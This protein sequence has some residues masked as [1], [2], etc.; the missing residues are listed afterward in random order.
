MVETQTENLFDRR[1]DRREVPAL[2]VH[3]MVLGQDG[4]NLFAAGV[5]DMDFMAPPV[6]LEALQQRLAHGIFGYE[7]VP[8]GLMPA[9]TAWLQSR[10]S[11]QVDPA[12][13]LRAPNVLNSLAIAASL[14]TEP[15]D[16]VIVQS[17]VFFD[18]YDILRENNRELVLNPLILNDG[19]YEMDFDGLERLAAEPRTRMIYLCNPHNPVGRVW[20]KAELQQL[21]EICA[22]YN[23]LVVSDEIHGDVTFSGHRY[24]PFAA[25]GPAYA[26]NSIICLSPAK[27]FNI[28]ACCSAFTVIANVARRKAFQVENSRLT[29]NKNNAFSSAAMVAAYSRGGEWLDDALSYIEGNLALVRTHLENIPNVKLIEPDGTFLLWLD[30]RALGLSP[31]DLTAFLRQ[32]AGWAVTR[33]QAFGVEGEGFARL[34]IACTR[35]TLSDALQ[36]LSNAITEHS[37][38]Q[39]TGVPQ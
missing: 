21:G 17:P 30:F 5:A 34:N 4:E 35:A 20:T 7:A 12:H 32:R 25:L 37:N 16:G 11:W 27:S 31:S 38:T 10:H 19:R 9:L 18:F 23:V 33:G 28:A 6:V 1:I 29:V 8:A 14:F 15:G 36:Q 3:P 2:K 22:R 24:T 13:I 26:D 39:K